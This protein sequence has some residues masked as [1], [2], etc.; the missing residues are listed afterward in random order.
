MSSIGITQNPWQPQMNDISCQF[1]QQFPNSFQGPLVHHHQ[2]CA[3]PLP[4]SSALQDFRFAELLGN[5]LGASN[6][7][8]K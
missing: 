2:G 7:T 8:E 1:K 6:E 3:E 5:D 4:A